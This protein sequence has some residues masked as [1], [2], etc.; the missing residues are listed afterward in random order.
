METAYSDKENK[1]LLELEA[2]LYQPFTSTKE[3]RQ[4]KG[5]IEALKNF[6][7]SSEVRKQETEEMFRE[8]IQE[9]DE[10]LGKSR[11]PTPQ[12][13]NDESMDESN[14]EYDENIYESNN[15]NNESMN[16]SNDENN[17]RKRKNE[18]FLDKNETKKKKDDNN[19]G[20]NNSSS[21][22]IGPSIQGPSTENNNGNDNSTS[23]ARILLL[24]SYIGYL[25]DILVDILNNSHF[26]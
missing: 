26:F 6:L 15:E 1:K 17:N 18:D 12:P 21:G 3:V 14:N 5:R 4:L 19:D 10:G 25:L 7:E 13:S 2:R 20:D 23:N 16:E 11:S 8:E 24:F 9:T 22:G